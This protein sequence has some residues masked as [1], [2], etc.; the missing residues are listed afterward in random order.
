[1]DRQGAHDIVCGP[2]H[3]LSLAVLGRGIRT[4]H[5]ELDTLREEKGTRGVVIE[6]TPIV[7]LDDLDGEAELSGHPKQRSGGWETSQTW[8]ARGKSK[9]S[10]RNHRPR[11]DSTCS[12]KY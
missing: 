10:E 12:K 1:L 2:N 4:R 11:P 5:A 8:H 7:T 9:S 6:L 3:A